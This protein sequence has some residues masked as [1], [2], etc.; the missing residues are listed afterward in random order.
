MTD[1]T[2][3]PQ[4][5]GLPLVDGLFIL[6][7]GF[8]KPLPEAYKAAVH[9]AALQ[10]VVDGL[11]EQRAALIGQAGLPHAIFLGCGDRSHRKGASGAWTRG[12]STNHKAANTALQSN[13]YPLPG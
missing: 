1:I 6:L 11:E 9:E 4:R 3:Q 7:V 10:Q 5:P 8:D 13:S 12:T 2:S